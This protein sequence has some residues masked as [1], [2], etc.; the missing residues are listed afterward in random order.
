MPKDKSNN[1]AIVKRFDFESKLQRMSVIVKKQTKEME[2]GEYHC[3]VK[4]SPE[5]IKSLSKWESI[6]ANYDLILNEY[7]CKGYRMIAFG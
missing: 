4:G 6:P 3:I 7:T 2:H 5:M 1:L